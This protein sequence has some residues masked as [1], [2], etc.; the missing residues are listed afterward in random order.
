[1]A[2]FIVMT[3]GLLFTALIVVIDGA[4]SGRSRIATT[5]PS[6]SG[7]TIPTLPQ[8]GTLGEDVPADACGDGTYRIAGP[9][10]SIDGIGVGDIVTTDCEPKGS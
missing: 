1:V 8:I 5:V 10:W 4:W 9:P 6:D 2:G 7:S 3:A